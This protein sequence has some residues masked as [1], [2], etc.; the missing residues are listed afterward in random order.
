[1]IHQRF[2]RSGLALAVI[3]IG[4]AQSNAQLAAPDTACEK[5]LSLADITRDGS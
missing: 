3:S 5:L 4:T 2:L 1:M